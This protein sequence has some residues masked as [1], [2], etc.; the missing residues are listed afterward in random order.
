MC[1]I[2][3]IHHYRLHRPVDAHLL[4]RMTDALAHRGPDGRGVFV[5]GAIGLGHRR[6]AILDPTERGAQPMVSS[7]GRTVVTFNG[8][9]YNFRELRRD[10]EKRGCI[11]R[12][13]TDTEVI[14]EA[15]E[16][17]GEDAIDA[18]N[19]MYA[20]AL[21]DRQTRS[22]F[23][24]R[25]RFGIKPLYVLDD[26]D[27]IRFASEIKALFADPGLDRVPDWNGLRSVLELGYAG[28]PYT[29]FRGIAQLEPAQLL[30]VSASGVVKRR[31]WQPSS[32][33]GAICRA[34]AL[35]RFD[36]AL[37]SAV[38]AQMVSDVPIGAFLSGGLDST[39]VVASMKSHANTVRAFTAAFT[40][41]SFDESAIARDTAGR[42]SIDHTIETIDFDLTGTASAIA[43]QFDDPFADASALAV[44]HICRI[45]S[46]EVKVVLSGD[47]AD[48]ILAGY[49][50]YAADAV[51]RPLHAGGRTVRSALQF[52]AQ[53]GAAADHPYAA[54]NVA[55]RL[56]RVSAEP[57]A[58]RHA[59]WRR[60]WFP[61]DETTLLTTEA[62][63]S[64]YAAADPI[65]EYARP[66]REARAGQ[67]RMS[68][69]LTAD[70]LHY[71]PNDMLTKVDRMSMAHSLEVRVPMLEHHF[72]DVVLSLE[73]EELRRPFTKG[74]RILRQSIHRML[75]W[76][77]VA[78]RKHGFVVPIAAAL[79]GS[80]GEMVADYAGSAFAR[81]AGVFRG[82]PLLRLLA[83]H[84][85]REID[86]SFQLYTALMVLL[87]WKRFFA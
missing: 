27:S 52:L 65:D 68:A 20:I 64:L 33:R 80:L 10:L 67:S 15:W 38:H 12:T 28:S 18:L 77:D 71:L 1:G 46:R 45:A 78:R 37:D 35:D 66:F 63:Q 44:Y 79:R 41:R 23:L 60:Y 11:F 22:L 8:E 54:K 16:A 87:W 13:E 42:L 70:L 3:G 36:A 51:A 55:L 26:G 21:W 72:V 4:D 83:R 56:A 30:T 39:R 76:F 43:A 32:R 69:A 58:R 81:D 29:C 53:L 62:L 49:A 75:P 57:E 5:D 74:K 17:W 40:Q 86:A 73:E 19:G 47:G 25:D 50:T 84:R 7:S 48:E 6:L 34:E 82:E 14:L 61:A 24:I 85:R 59:S 2:A 31:T 9:I